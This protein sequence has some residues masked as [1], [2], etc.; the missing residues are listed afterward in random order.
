M[1]SDELRVIPVRGIP[2]I[3]EGNDL[4][5][6]IST[7]VE[8]E[9]FDVVVITQKIVSK[10]E[11]RVVHLAEDDLEGFGRLV[12]AES[13]RV[14][15]VRGGLAITETHH[16]MICANAGI[17]RSNTEPNT[18]TLLPV[19]PD[20]SARAIRRKL[21]H[22]QGRRLGVIITDTFGRTWRN[23]VTDVAIGCDGIAGVIDLRGR[24]DAQGRTLQATEVCVADEIAG[25]AELVK[26]K[27]AQIPVV[28]VRGLSTDLFRDSSV[29][30]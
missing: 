14:L 7:C 13:R 19:D 27:S 24:T 28:I 8:L 23:G 11:G 18:V 15:R 12:A 22:L 20:R 25:A 5:E 16:G 21:S 1:S 3:S 6:I 29:K 9:D 2:E 10:A 26:G 17:D 30:G 4:A